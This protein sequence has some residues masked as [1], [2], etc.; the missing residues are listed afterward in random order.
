MTFN[1][2]FF[3]FFLKRLSGFPSSIIHMSTNYPSQKTYVR[4]FQD[5]FH[6]I[7]MSFS[8]APHRGF[9]SSRPP[10]YL[11]ALPV[12]HDSSFQV[13]TWR[14]P[15]SQGLCTPKNPMVLLIIIP[16]LNGYF[17]GNI[18]NIFRQTHM[19]W[20]FFL[21]WLMKMYEDSRI[22]DIDIYIYIYWY[23]SRI[24]DI[25][26]SRYFVVNQRCRRFPKIGATFLFHRA[27]RCMRTRRSRTPSK[28]ALNS[29]AVQAGRPTMTRKRMYSTVIYHLWSIIRIYMGMIFK[30]S[31][32]VCRFFQLI[33]AIPWRYLWYLI[34][35]VEYVWMMS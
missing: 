14:R 33:L 2:W 6:V 1:F 32:D 12:L 7:S 16:F 17:I 35:D 24:I 25:K 34:F 5:H 11:C 8:A 19:I 28:V 21:M 22:F 20:W 4:S 31:E 10:T 3:T 15:F 23:D 27:A 26:Y 30:Y 9:T 13:S 18:P 29:A